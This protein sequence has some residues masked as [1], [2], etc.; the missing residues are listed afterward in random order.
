M[1]WRIILEGFG[2]GALL[3]LVC[4][5]AIRKGA[6]GAVHLYGPVVQERCV[7]LGLITR[8][9]IKQNSIRFKLVCI[10]GYIAYVLVCVY[11]VNG[12]RG[13]WTGFWQLFVIL[14]VMNLIDRFFIDEWWVGHTNAWI[15]PGTEDLQ[16]YI[17]TT[18]KKHKWLAGTVGMAVI[19]LV[20][21]GIMAVIIH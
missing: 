2:L 17:T 12:V 5:F 4:M 10:P 8:E 14:S 20:L 21:S 19:A 3:V 11:A 18:D 9:K 16:P 15:I 6:I 13:F 7:E 1:V